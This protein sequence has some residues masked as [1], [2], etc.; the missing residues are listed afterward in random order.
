MREVRAL[1]EAAKEK[2]KIAVGVDEED[3]DGQ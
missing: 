2:I 1:Q 3:A